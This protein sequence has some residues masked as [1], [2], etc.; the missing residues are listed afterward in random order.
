MYPVEVAIRK[1]NEHLYQWTIY[2][3]EESIFF[4]WDSNGRQMEYI[5]SKSI[6]KAIL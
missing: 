4:I 3:K 1:D 2:I 6:P 5:M